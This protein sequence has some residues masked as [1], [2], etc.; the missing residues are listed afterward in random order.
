MTPK[1]KQLFPD[2]YLARTDLAQDSANLL[3]TCPFPQNTPSSHAPY[4]SRLRGR[5]AWGPRTAKKVQSGKPML[6]SRYVVVSEESRW[7]IVRGGRRYPE[8]YPNKNQAVCSAIAFAERDGLAGRRA[9]VMVR[10]EDGHFITEWVY[11]EDLHP[12]EAAHP[13]LLSSH[14]A[15]R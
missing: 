3:D 15:T 8:T 9:E 14:S 4:P 6:H 7:Q 11:G 1:L 5:V 13:P 12:D 10:H 2:M